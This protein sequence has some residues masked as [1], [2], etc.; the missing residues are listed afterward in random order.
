MMKKPL[1]P[2][3]YV[4]C[5]EYIKNGF[6]AYK[7]ALT[8][9]YSESYANCKAGEL[10]KHPNI[11]ERLVKAYEKMETKQLDK[12]AISF[13]DKANILLSIINDII[14][15][16]GSE[17]KRQYYKDAIKAMSELNKMQ[18]DY[19]PDKRMNMTINATL[20][21]LQEAR[22]AYDEY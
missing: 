7:A 15:K 22:K 6:N 13:T 17:P 1:T 11:Q 18:G 14:P 21:K 20:D 3:Q 2:M 12:L 4:F 8:A 10:I 19:A 5:S 16:D 9:G